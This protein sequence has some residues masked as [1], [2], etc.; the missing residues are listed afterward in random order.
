MTRLYDLPIAI[1]DIAV[2]LL[3]NTM[4]RNWKDSRNAPTNPKEL[5]KE[6]NEAILALY[7]PEQKKVQNV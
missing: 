4:E 5:A 3:A 1:Q 7:E 2:S 6:I